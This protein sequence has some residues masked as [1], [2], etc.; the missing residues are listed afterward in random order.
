[1]RTTVDV[2]KYI[3]TDQSK[4]SFG[5]HDSI[6]Q[7]YSRWW[8]G[9]LFVMSDL[10][11]L[12]MALGAAYVLRQTMSAE[13]LILENYLRLIPFFLIFL[14]FYA[15]RGL[16]PAVG[17]SPVEELRRLTE[18]TSMVY[19]AITAFTFWVRS[20]EAYSR[21]TFGFAWIFSLVLVQFNR[22][23]LRIVAVKCGVWGEPVAIVGYGSQGRSVVDFLRKNYRFGMR[24]ALI[25]DGLEKTTGIEGNDRSIPRLEITT[26]DDSLTLPLKIAGISTAILIVP[27]MPKELQSEIIDDGRFG[28]KRL[29][30]ISAFGWI[31][32]MGVK[33]YDLEGILGLEVRRN[34]LKLW[35]RAIKSFLD[36]LFI[37]LGSVIGLPFTALIALIIRLDSKG[38]IFYQ[39]ERLGRGGVTI[40]VWKFR[41]MVPDGDLILEDYLTAHPEL[42]AEWETN[43]KLKNDP[44]V[45]RVGKFL[46]KTS[47]DELPQVWNVIKGEMSLVGPRPIVSEEIKQYGHVY[48]LYTQVLPGMTGLWQVS[49]RNDVGYASRVRLDEYYVRN[50]SIWLDIYILLRTVLVV[51]R[52]NGA[53]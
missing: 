19:L 12:G 8:M 27:E 34:L 23:L 28:F 2:T 42:R 24:P 7:R 21:L 43:H 16:Y 30:M 32:S 53:Y 31:G 4:R 36:Y 51:L 9:F 29:I 47:L 45:T 3:Q 40:K 35:D 46:R 22:W 5:L 26:R 10:L 15:I 44:R 37:I 41:T 17:L 11:G 49:G 25:I 50:W 18:S 52:R 48:K 6:L 38:K 14:A 39:H 33:S 20:A 13:R 1:M